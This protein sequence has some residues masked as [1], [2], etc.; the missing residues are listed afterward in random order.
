[1]PLIEPTVSHAVFP[2][3]RSREK[4]NAIESVMSL[5]LGSSRSAIFAFA[6][7]R[8]RSTGSEIADE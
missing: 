4:A 5:T 2:A 1:L 6:S 3:N 8:L 7:G